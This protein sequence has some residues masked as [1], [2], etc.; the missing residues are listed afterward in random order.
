MMDQDFIWE[1]GILSKKKCL[2]KVEFNTATLETVLLRHECPERSN[3]T[4]R[5]LVEVYPF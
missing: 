4:T 5:V 2:T 3:L 1:V